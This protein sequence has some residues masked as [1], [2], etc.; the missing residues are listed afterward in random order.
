MN[1]KNGREPIP[2]VEG[3]YFTHEP[4]N[5]TY[6]EVVRSNSNGR[7]KT[8]TYQCNFLLYS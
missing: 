2:L 4:S 6:M 3:S 1:Q 8:C 5:I 7:S